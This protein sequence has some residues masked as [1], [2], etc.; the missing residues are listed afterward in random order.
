MTSR[1]RPPSIILTAEEKVEKLKTYQREYQR[2]RYISNAEVEKKL[3]T[4]RRYLK[5]LKSE[6]P[7]K[8]E[9]LQRDFDRLKINFKPIYELRSLL[10]NLPQELIEEV[11]LERTR[12]AE[13]LAKRSPLDI[14]RIN[15]NI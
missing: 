9:E 8:V 3:Q 5:E 2:N 15:Q 14:Q 4:N 1:G 12:E 13:E 11:L 6:N 10:A 7:D